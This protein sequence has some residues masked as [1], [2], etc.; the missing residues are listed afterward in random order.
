MIF[1]VDAAHWPGIA[2]WLFRNTPGNLA[3]SGLAFAAGISLG[4][5]K[6]RKALRELHSKL[7]AH[8]AESMRAHEAIH[9][10]LGIPPTTK[11][12]T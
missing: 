11:G 6:G 9:H 4:W 5:V 8:H 3:A 12:T 10:Q 1:A 2:G 7:D